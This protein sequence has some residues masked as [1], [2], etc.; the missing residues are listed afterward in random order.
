MPELARFQ[1]TRRT[2]RNRISADGQVFVY[3]EHTSPTALLQAVIDAV[4]GTDDDTATSR[5]VRALARGFMESDAFLDPDAPTASRGLES[6]VPKLDQ[7]LTRHP[8]ASLDDLNAMLFAA[9]VRLGFED[10]TPETAAATIVASDEWAMFRATMGD[11][12]VA[13]L[14]GGNGATVVEGGDREKLPTH[15]KA[16]RLTRWVVVCGT[17][18]HSPGTPPPPY[19]TAAKRCARRRRTPASPAARAAPAARNHRGGPAG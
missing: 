5:A 2:E 9:A 10:V 4:Q 18:S 8:E 13:L 19:G 17:P 6:E 14:L 1:I 12:L 15:I 3:L 11:S 7:W 16:A